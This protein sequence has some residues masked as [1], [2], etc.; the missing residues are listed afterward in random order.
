MQANLSPAARKIVSNTAIT[1]FLFAALLAFFFTIDISTIVIVLSILISLF[2]LY[3]LWLLKESDAVSLLVF[4]FGTTACFFL[5]SEV[6]I[7]DWLRALS[8]LI[9]AILAFVLSNYLINLTP[10]FVGEGA[11]LYKIALAIIFTEVFWVIS[12]FTASQISK[13]AIT[14]LL[15]FNFL[16]PLRDIMG[17]KFSVQKFAFL[18]ILLLAIKL[19]PN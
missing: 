10:G 16:F 3:L 11:I 14:A 8:V 19:F 12:F 15:F 2:G 18:T 5:F 4:F 17:G 13:G 7:V 1:S 6:I 9:F